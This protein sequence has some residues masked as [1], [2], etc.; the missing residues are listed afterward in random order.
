MVF[1]NE[2]NL[3]GDAPIANKFS[4]Q[5]TKFDVVQGHINAI[6]SES[7][8]IE[9]IDSGKTMYSGMN[10]IKVDVTGIHGNISSLTTRID[11]QSQQITQ[12]NSKQ[13]TYEATLDEFS[14]SLSDTQ[15]DLRRQTRILQHCNLIQV[16]SRLPYQT[17]TQLKHR[18]RDMRQ[19]LSLR[20]LVRRQTMQRPKPMRQKQTQMRRQITN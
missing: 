6:V 7:E 9:L 16:N 10:D 2:I 11:G 20:R 18:H 8:M 14:A 3:Y 15:S 1:E 19:A 12:I 13:A 4:T 17:H 5:D